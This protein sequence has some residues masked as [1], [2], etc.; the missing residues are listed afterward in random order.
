[1]GAFVSRFRGEQLGAVLAVPRAP[2]LRVPQDP[3]DRA[4]FGSGCR[5]VYSGRFDRR[6]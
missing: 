3:P 2:F 5:G 6:P 1:M 4:V